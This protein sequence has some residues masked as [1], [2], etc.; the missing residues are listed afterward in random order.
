M[1]AKQ[2]RCWLSRHLPPVLPRTASH[3]Q[4]GILIISLTPKSPP[5]AQRLPAAE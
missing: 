2:Q 4:E 5:E 1:T 3:R